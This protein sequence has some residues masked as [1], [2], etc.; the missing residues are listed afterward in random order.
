MYVFL[1]SSFF[2]VSQEARKTGVAEIFFLYLDWVDLQRGHLYD[3]IQFL[4]VWDLTFW[5]IEFP[6]LKSI[7]SFLRLAIR[8]FRI[9][10]DVIHVKHLFLQQ[11]LFL[12]VYFLFFWILYGTFEF[13]LK[14]L[15]GH[16]LFVAWNCSTKSEKVFCR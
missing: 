9:V 5:E 7:S 11:L 3:W 6:S 2:L 15:A 13:S 16:L 10:I 1:S 4:E 12:Y 8:F 14:I